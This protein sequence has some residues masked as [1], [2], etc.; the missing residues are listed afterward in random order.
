MTGEG[1]VPPRM[2]VPVTVTVC[3]LVAAGAAEV[4]ADFFGCVL[5]GLLVTGALPCAVVSVVASWAMAHWPVPRPAT[6]K[7]MEMALRS[8][9]V[10]ML[11]PLL[12]PD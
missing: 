10:F 3:R 2:R 8:V 9:R 1:V 11:R 5:A 7:V 4:S 12:S 6:S